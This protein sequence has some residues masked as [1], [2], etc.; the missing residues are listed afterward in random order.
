MAYNPSVRNITVDISNLT[1]IPNDLMVQTKSVY[2]SL[3]IPPGQD[4]IKSNSVYLE[5]KAAA[6]FTFAPKT[7]E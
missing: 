5:S 1:Y 2:T 7:E 6:M 4:K 3:N